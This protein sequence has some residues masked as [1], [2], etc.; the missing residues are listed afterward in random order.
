MG[1]QIIYVQIQGTPACKVICRWTKPWTS[2][3]GCT[4]ER[5]FQ[6]V[7]GRTV[8]PRLTVSLSVWKLADWKV[9]QKGFVVKI[10]L[11]LVPWHISSFP[12]NFKFEVLIR[13]WIMTLP[14]WWIII[15]C[16]IYW[17]TFDVNFLL[18]SA[19]TNQTT[20][21]KHTINIKDIQRINLDYIVPVPA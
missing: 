4:V 6:R 8:E 1:I 16:Q 10:S 20:A 18:G 21:L 5:Q 9:V 7:A 13:H 3:H 19:R 17:F 11:Q 2:Q 12:F 14:C 15:I